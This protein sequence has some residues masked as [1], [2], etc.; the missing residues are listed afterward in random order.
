MPDPLGHRFP[1]YPSASVRHPANKRC[2]SAGPKVFTDPF[3]P[4]VEPRF[5]EGPWLRCLACLGRGHTS[6]G[7]PLL[8]G[9]TAAFRSMSPAHFRATQRGA[10]LMPVPNGQ[11]L[12]IDDHVGGGNVRWASLNFSCSRESD[13][14]LYWSTR[15][16]KPCAH[17][18]GEFCTQGVAPREYVDRSVAVLRYSGCSVRADVST[19][20]LAAAWRI[21]PWWQSVACANSEVVLHRV[22]PA[23][24]IAMHRLEDIVATGWRSRDDLEADPDDHTWGPWAE[25]SSYMGS[26]R[27]KSRPY[28]PEWLPI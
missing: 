5:P 10:T 22:H 12:S 27:G 3:V 21:S 17:R 14:A 26:H 9:S 7:C 18:G 4:S 2:T 16:A 20:A 1:T 23:A 19:P 15:V 24:V 25:L 13:P 28:R 8:Q 6:Y 11:L